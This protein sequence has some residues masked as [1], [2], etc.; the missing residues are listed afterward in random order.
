MDGRADLLAD[1]GAAAAGDDFF[2]SGP[3]LAAE[4]TTHSLVL[5]TGDT[6]AVLPLLVRDVPGTD[7]RDAISPYGFPGGWCAGGPVDPRRVDLSTLGLVSVF[8]RDRLGSPA[9]GGGTV[10]GRVFVHDPALPRSLSKSFRRDVRRNEH[11]GRRVE[12]VAGG[13]V[14]D[15]TLAGFAAA[16]TETMTLVGAAARYFFD[17]AY[18]RSCLD[19]A[20][21]WLAVVRDPDGAVVAGELVVRSDGMLHSY[22]AGTATAHRS[23]SPGKNATLRAIELADALGRR[24]NVGGGVAADDTLAASKRSYANAEDRFVTHELIT[25]PAVYAA[26]GDGVDAGSFFPAYRAPRSAAGAASGADRGA[27]TSA[28]PDRNRRSTSTT[29]STSSGP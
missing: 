21:S 11:A 1:G 19:V 3:F 10:R 29:R 22:L 27:G 24:L 6:R 14:D 17:A 25:D 28:A 20:G 15:A 26:L 4:G 8:V 5:D 13:D 23:G 16:Y 12:L 9:L 18:L 2:R 7:H